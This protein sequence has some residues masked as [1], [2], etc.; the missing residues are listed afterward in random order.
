MK[1][2]H[3]ILNNP[4]NW[5]D[6]SINSFVIENPIIY[7]DFI[8]ELYD[9][10]EGS[11][12]KFVLSKDEEILELSKYTEMISDII[13]INTENKKIITGIIKELTDISINERHLELTE[14]YRKINEEL[15]EIIF[16]SGMDIVYDDINDISQIL[17]LYNVKPN[18]EKTSLAE[19]IL[20]YMELCEKY[21]KK[22]LF[23]FLNLHSYFTRHELE[24]LF[25]NI[26]YSRHN[27]FI[28]ERYDYKAL[29]QEI[30]RII[31]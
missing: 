29:P 26:Q 22:K 7:R 13:Q 9:Q 1:L 11:R 10:L 20:F 8:K 3:P 23:V 4:I 5:K 24:L 30:K 6:N 19:R 28:I 27:V 17:K 21:Q 18:D 14:L 31:D 25:K 15:N 12:G 16:S 2:I